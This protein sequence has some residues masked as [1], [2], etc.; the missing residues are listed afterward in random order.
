LTVLKAADASPSP[1]NSEEYVEAFFIP[2]ISA[3]SLLLVL[4]GQIAIV[5]ADYPSLVIEPLRTLGLRGA[6]LARVGIR[7]SALPESLVRVDSDRLHR[8]WSILSSADL[9]SIAFGMAD[10]LCRRAVAHAASRVQFPGLF[11]DEEARD[12]IGKFGVVKKMLAD[13]SARRFV[14]ETLDHDLSPADFSSAAEIQA[15]LI[16]AVAAECLGT[17]PGSIAYNAGQVFGGAG[18]SEDDILSKFYRDADAFRFLG[19]ANVE[20]LGRHGKEL[21]ESF[22]GDGRK[23]ADITHETDLFESLTQR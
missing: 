8:A 3:R 11:H 5:P 16:K 15:R 1:T 10:Q 17:A 4:P 9:T 6:G 14:I 23:L 19:V 7:K 13:M 2:A 22:F 20:V 21:L 18:Y 12:T